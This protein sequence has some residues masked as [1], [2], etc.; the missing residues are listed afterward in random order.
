MLQKILIISKKCFRHKLSRI[1][2]FFNLHPELEPLPRW[3][4]VCSTLSLGI[5]LC[6]LFPAFSV[7]GCMMPKQSSSPS[8]SSHQGVEFKMLSMCLLFLL[9]IH[10][11][12]QWTHISIT[13]G[14]ELEALKDLQ[15]FKFRTGKTGSL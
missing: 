2:Y 14:D 4:T 11:S 1:Y 12:F 5:G 13:P 9:L 6:Y 15:F 10:Y 8:I 7:K 3:V